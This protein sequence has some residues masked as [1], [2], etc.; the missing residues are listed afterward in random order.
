AVG[1]IIVLP[2]KDGRL[3]AVALNAKEEL[4]VSITP[5]PST[6]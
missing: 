6:A 1:N 5:N 4:Q 2:L 3:A